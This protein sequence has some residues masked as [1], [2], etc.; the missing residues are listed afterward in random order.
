VRCGIN[1]GTPVK[2][3]GSRRRWTNATSA[4]AHSIIVTFH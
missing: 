3:G 2:A 4:P 1:S